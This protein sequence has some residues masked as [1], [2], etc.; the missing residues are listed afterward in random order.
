METKYTSEEIAAKIAS[1]PFWGHSIQLPFGIVTPG[2]VMCNVDTM[3]RLNL[4]QNLTDMTVLDIGTWDGFYSFECEKRGARVMAIDNLNR[5]KKNDEICFKSQG[6]SGFEIIKDILDSQVEFRE[7][8]VYQIDREPIGKFDIVLFLGV[9][10]HLKHPLLALEKVAQVVEQDLYIETEFIRAPFTNRPI[11]EYLEH[12]YLNEDPT[13]HCRP[14]VSWLKNTLLDLG[15]SSVD[16]LYKT[17][18]SIFNIYRMV[19]DGTIFCPGRIIIKASK[20]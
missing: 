13:N 9:L 6:N 12:C 20:K 4:S 17:P 3:N 10:Y 19:V 11:I 1:V 2:R 14:N 8:D 15:F 18:T 16:I 7:M 5:L